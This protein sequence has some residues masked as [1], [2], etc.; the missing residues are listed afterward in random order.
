MCPGPA[1][2]A[3]V[4][5]RIA[6]R[7]NQLSTSAEFVHR[8]PPGTPA[9]GR[10]GQACGM[11]IGTMLR[12]RREKAA[13]TQTELADRAG[14]SQSTVSAVERGTRRP[15][16]TIIGRVLA[17]L[18]LQ[19]HLATE[20]IDEPEAELDAAIETMRAT[21]LVDRLT[22]ARFDGAALLR[23]L[24]PATPVVEG[25]AGA[26]L[27]GAPVPLRSLDV[28]VEREQLGALAEVIQRSYAERWS[29]VWSRWGM[30]S[31][32]PRAP[33]PMRW[34]TLDGE[35]RIR[36]VD[37]PVDAVTVLVG[38]LPVAVRPL[39]EIESTDRRVARA[40]ARLHT[41]TPADPTNPR[42]PT[43]PNDPGSPTAQLPPD[44][45]SGPDGPRCRS[46]LGGWARWGVD[47]LGVVTFRRRLRSWLGVG[48]RGGG[49]VRPRT[50][51][52]ARR[53]R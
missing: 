19:L 44:G 48:G 23:M 1:I 49:R 31:P 9:E 42:R 21:P 27:H 43:D 46:R 35:F 7:R 29:D 36:L 33:G 47:G 10:G 15:S 22:G 30:E 3:V 25:A 53:G 8:Y 38:D 37:T 4:P 50:G 5:A 39:H 34:Q 40:L 20:P 24:A 14:V 13:L 28:V 26:V 16:L 45:P 18:G 52:D 41:A 17:A 12:D 2:A 6:S 51:P 11:E 32:H